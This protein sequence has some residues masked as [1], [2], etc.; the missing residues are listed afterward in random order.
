MKLQYTDSEGN[1]QYSTIAESKAVKGE[2]VQLVN[3]NYMIPEDASDMYIYIETAD[4]TNS[5]YVD[6]LIGAVGGT[7]IA[8][9]GSLDFEIIPGDVNCDG[10]INIFDLCAAKTGL[11]VGFE[12]KIQQAAAD[13]DGNGEADTTDLQLIQ[14]YIGS[15]ITEFPV[16]EPENSEN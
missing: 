14:K 3:T 9:E 7:G 4:S 1:T 13:V 6:E 15:V 16:G 10:S 12:N 5:F 2:W 11:T 8:G